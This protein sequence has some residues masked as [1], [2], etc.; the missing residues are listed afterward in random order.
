MTAS[1]ACVALPADRYRSGQFKYPSQA[2][3]NLGLPSAQCL[4]KSIITTSSRCNNALQRSQ[5]K[6]AL[7]CDSEAPGEATDGCR[8]LKSA[9]VHNRVPETQIMCIPLN[10]QSNDQISSLWCHSVPSVAR[11]VM[12]T[13]PCHCC[14]THG[15]CWQDWEGSQNAQ[16]TSENSGIYDWHL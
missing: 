2:T 14:W 15:Q 16:N 3:Y 12:L 1:F 13:Q 6:K 7:G 9:Q 4:T 8:A 11:P 10:P 5:P